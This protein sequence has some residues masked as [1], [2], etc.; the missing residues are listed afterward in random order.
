MKILIPLRNSEMDFR[1]SGFNENI[2]CALHPVLVHPKYLLIHVH[3][4]IFV[5]YVVV[6][7][8]IVERTTW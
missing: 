5:N 4:Y 3:L 7:C 1:F 8:L 2:E 6:L